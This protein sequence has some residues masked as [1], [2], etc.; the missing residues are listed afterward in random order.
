[1]IICLWLLNHSNLRLLNRFWWFKLWLNNLY[2]LMMMMVSI[3]INIR[4]FVFTTITIFIQILSLL[5]HYLLSL[6]STLIINA[7][8][9]SF[10]LCLYFVNNTLIDMNISFEPLVLIINSNRLS[11][12]LLT[13]NN[14]LFLSLFNVKHCFNFSLGHVLCIIIFNLARDFFFTE[15]IFSFS[16]SKRFFIFLKW[17]GLHWC[18]I[19]ARSCENRH[20]SLFLSGCWII[21]YREHLFSSWWLHFWYLHW[22]F[23]LHVSRF[24]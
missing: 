14:G 24:D 22:L 10:T 12:C 16:M 8:N 3:T 11:T 17:N 15:F 5:S 20:K 21:E 19:R 6:M 9:I 4:L 7:L 18:V 23:L 2:G 1:M 13:F